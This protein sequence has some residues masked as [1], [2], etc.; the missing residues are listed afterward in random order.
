MMPAPTTAADGDDEYEVVQ[1]PNADDDTGDDSS[2]SSDSDSDDEEKDEQVESR[3][4]PK[5]WDYIGNYRTLR[6]FSGGEPSAAF[7]P[8]RI[9]R[10]VLVTEESTTS[11]PKDAAIMQKVVA[12]ATYRQ[13]DATLV[14]EVAWAWRGRAYTTK[15]VYPRRLL[16]SYN[17]YLRV[18]RDLGGR[19]SSGV[20]IDQDPE[21]GTILWT[22]NITKKDDD[23]DAAPSMTEGKS[24]RVRDA[25]PL[26][27]CRS[28]AFNGQFGLVQQIEGQASSVP[29]LIQR[30][31]HPL[32]LVVDVATTDNRSVEWLESVDCGKTAYAV[33]VEFAEGCEEPL[34]RLVEAL[35]QQMQCL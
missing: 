1:D 21:D 29:A 18:M 12:V 33:R 24:R 34:Q 2:T 20:N 31:H 35:N 25:A 19:L 32:I 16:A 3:F 7:P 8:L 26:V 13:A 4:A 30:V 28:L 27:E 10:T 15:Q 6:P 9:T 17:G 5:R 14:V 22:Y 11:T 23:D